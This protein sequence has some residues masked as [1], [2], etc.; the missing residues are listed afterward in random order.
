VYDPPPPA[1]SVVVRTAAELQA[2]LDGARAGRH[3]VL[4]DGTYAGTFTLP[5]TADGTAARPV[6]V[7][8]RNR[9]AATIDGQL[10]LGGDHA[11]AHGLRF[12]G[13]EFGVRMAG[14]H[15]AVT[16]NRFDAA[17][18][19]FLASPT[20]YYRIGANRF[21]G[22]PPGEGSTSF[23]R[24]RADER[25]MPDHGRIYRNHFVDRDTGNSESHVLYVCCQF[26]EGDPSL[27]DLII[28]RNFIDSWRRR[29]LY[30][31]YG[32]TIRYNTA[33]M[34][35]G[36]AEF[37]FRGGDDGE[38]V[39]NYIQGTLQIQIRG[40]NHDVRGNEWVDTEMNVV[41]RWYV[42][43]NQKTMV[44]PGD[45]ARIVGNRGPLNLGWMQPRAT[46]DRPVRWVRVEG[47]DGPIVRMHVDPATLV[48][49]PATAA[50]VPRPARLTA[51][52]VGPDYHP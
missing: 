28:E 5:A 12:V 43:G 23:I 9:H 16:R 22:A 44:P 50:A 29:G 51:D 15:G 35:K 25:D 40:K 10:V 52:S 2:A 14:D 4:G 30:S 34:K 31:K 33:V 36:R 39:G 37:G 7:R 48:V 6:V 3:V 27:T 17:N 47:H 19:V 13:A 41:S 1:D 42:R 49:L 8:A 32:G 20:K 21:G 18:G 11:W 24:I 45:S 38:F 26:D 46:F